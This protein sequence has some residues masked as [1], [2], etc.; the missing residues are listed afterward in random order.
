[1]MPKRRRGPRNIW[2]SPSSLLA[3]VSK[4]HVRFL[5]KTL[6]R[7]RNFSRVHTPCIPDHRITLQEA[8]EQE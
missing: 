2:V 3:E 7:N 5:Y 4:E 6:G 8:L 1:M